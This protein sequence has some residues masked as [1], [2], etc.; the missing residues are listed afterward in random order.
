MVAA[1]DELLDYLAMSDEPQSADIILGLGSDSTDVPERVVE[2][3]DMGLAPWVLFAG[4]RGRLTGNLQG[5]EAAFLKEVAIERG[6][7]AESILLE[8]QSTNTLQNIR[9]S[10][11][12]LSKHKIIPSRV[13]L[14]TQPVLQR[15]AWATARRQWAGVEFLNCPPKTDATLTKRLSELAVGEIKRLQRYA[16]KG[17]IE[18]QEMPAR[19]INAYQTA[20]RPL[21]DLKGSSA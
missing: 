10:A 18:P 8:E 20:K 15:R 21:A 13:I 7:P 16:A 2:L 12:L 4:G 19:V 5:T 6:L 1:L 11:A 9:C 17:D 3:F 14:V